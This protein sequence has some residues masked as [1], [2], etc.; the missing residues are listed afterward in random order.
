[1][2][3]N[4]PNFD[5]TIKNYR[6]FSD[7][8]PVRISMREGFTALV[9]ANNSGKSS[10]LKLFYELRG[11]FSMIQSGGGNFLEAL[12]NP[13]G[14]SSTSDYTDLFCNAN[15]RNI[16]LEFEVHGDVDMKQHTGI[17]PERIVLTIIR[18][19]NM[20]SVKI[21]VDGATLPVNQGAN[22]HFPDPSHIQIEDTSI[23]M[24]NYYRIF[25]ALSSTV[26]IGAFRN[27][28][29]IGGSDSYYDMTIGEQFIMLWDS[30]KSGRVKKEN[31][32][33]LKLTEDIKRIFEY[34][35]LEI[36][37][38]SDN[39]TL[40]V[41]VNGK[42]YRLEE[43]GSGL[44]QFIVI[45]ANIAAKQPSWVLVDE[46]ELNLHASLQ[47]DFLTTL[48]FYATE[49]IMFATHNVG[50]ARVSAERIYSF[51][52]DD[53]RQVEVRDFEATHRLSE[54]F[55]ELNFAGHR[56]LGFDKVLLVEGT[57]EVKTLQQL[58][59][60]YGKDH[61]IVLIPLGGSSLINAESELELQE[62]KR[63]TTNLFSLID[64]E[65]ET[66]SAPLPSER[67]AFLTL[68]QKIGINCH[69][70]E[71]RAIENYLSERALKVVKGD[72]YSALGPY[73]KL[74]DASPSWGKQENWRIAREM[75]N[76]ELD[77]TDLGTFLQD[78]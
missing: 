35:S 20:F 22:I 78:L 9:G 53:D 12:R 13:R 19:T 18:D 1:M 42:P 55:G 49:G 3:E 45:L 54:F 52:R 68:C 62:V 26:Y 23:D 37:A 21:I 17:L 63:I 7:Q 56:D 8:K 65:R 6:C 73:E 32:A 70:L 76:E 44:A 39:R 36:N 67:Q 77:Q 71:R 74:E 5:I 31:D 40:Q 59:R 75:N 50:L 61:K 66:A 51:H 4:T 60:K 64:S 43:L 10:L 28:I 48:A 33:A 27:A 58:L 41:I 57:T 72:K 14:S 11:L 69:V 29:N 34:D 2:S 16:S 38:S 25:R 47:V 30:L 15:S 24:G 46:P